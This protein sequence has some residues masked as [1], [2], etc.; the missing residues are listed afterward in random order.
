MKKPILAKGVF[1]RSIKQLKKAVKDN[2]KL[3]LIYCDSNSKLFEVSE[4]EEITDDMT[5]DSYIKVKYGNNLES[6]VR[7]WEI[8]L[9]NEIEFYSLLDKHKKEMILF[10][11][12]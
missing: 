9:F 3:Y 8:T 5:K 12:K 10:N 4:I 1:L 7:Y 6:E 11:S 2:K